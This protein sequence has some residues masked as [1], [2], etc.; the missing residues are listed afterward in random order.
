MNSSS[1]SVTNIVNNEKDGYVGAESPN[2]RL[3]WLRLAYLALP[4]R[5]GWN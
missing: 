1:E 5:E 3:F 4:H 2:N